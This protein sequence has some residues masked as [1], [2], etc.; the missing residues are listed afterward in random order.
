MLT[1]KKELHG[2]KCRP[3][4]PHFIGS[5]RDAWSCYSLGV[6]RR[7]EIAYLLRM[8]DEEKGA[9]TWILVLLNQPIV[10]LSYREP[11]CLGR[12]NPPFIWGCLIVKTKRTLVGTITTKVASFRVNPHFYR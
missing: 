4:L 6:T 7:G 9:N 1:K 11:S 3:S 5:A 10:R 2:R 8:A 12:C